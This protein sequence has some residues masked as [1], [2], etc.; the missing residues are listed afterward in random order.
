MTEKQKNRLK[1]LKSKYYLKYFLIP[2]TEYI[3]KSNPFNI[4]SI[5]RCSEQLLKYGDVD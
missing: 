2:M 5:K 3:A 1:F 4:F